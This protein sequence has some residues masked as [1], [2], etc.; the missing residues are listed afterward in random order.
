MKREHRNLEGS[1]A[2]SIAADSAPA[3]ECKETDNDDQEISDVESDLVEHEDDYDDND[4]HFILNLYAIPN[5]N[6][7]NISH[8]VAATQKLLN[9]KNVKDATF[10]NLDS[11]YK[12]IKVLKS[13]NL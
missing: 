4:L 8:S 7:S 1:A 3:T 13:R 6:R 5:L 10:Q 2:L 12:I 9:R 11:E